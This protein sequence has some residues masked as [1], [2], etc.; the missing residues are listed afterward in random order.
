ML[1][2]SARHGLEALE[3]VKQDV[4][5]Q[6]NLRSSFKLILMDCNMPFMDGYDATEQIRQYLFEMDIEQ[7]IIV[8]VTGHTEPS[9]VERALNS[10]MNAVFSKPVAP[11]QLK[12]LL[13]CL[14]Y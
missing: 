9:Y 3:V 6:N 12:E 11:K 7:P 10:G 13:L 5:D 2:E 14:E 8:A 1:T 4:R